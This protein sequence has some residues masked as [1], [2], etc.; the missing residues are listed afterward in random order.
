MPGTSG[1][2]AV[3]RFSALYPGVRI[4]YMSGHINDAVLH[5]GLVR[6]ALSFLQKPFTPRELARR[7]RQSLDAS[8][9]G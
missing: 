8:P 5:H 4:L 1:R 6:D 3:S 2:E 9:T 7:V